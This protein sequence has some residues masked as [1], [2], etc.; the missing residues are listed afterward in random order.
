MAVEEAMVDEVAPERGRGAWRRPMM[1][2][3]I[4]SL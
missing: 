3:T 4:D 2:F 1:R